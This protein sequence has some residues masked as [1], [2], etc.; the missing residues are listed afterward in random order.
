MPR[1]RTALCAVALALSGIVPGALSFHL[2]HADVGAGARPILV[3][4]T[5]CRL[6][7]T[8][9]DSSVGGRTRPLGLAET[10]VLEGRG[11]AGSCELPNDA[12]GLLLNVTAVDPSQPTFMSV[13]PTGT[14][15]PRTSNLNPAPGQPPTPNAVSTGLSA[16]GRFSIFNAFGAVDVVV[17]V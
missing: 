6:L 8:R 3:S 13:F 12:V 5:P 7:D 16:D 11:H 15:V 4:I 10:Y 9:S 17:D 14:D 2:A 1:S